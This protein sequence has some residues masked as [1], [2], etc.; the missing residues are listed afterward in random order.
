MFIPTVSNIPNKIITINY[1]YYLN[2]QMHEYEI[3]AAHTRKNIDISMW[4][5]QNH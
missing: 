5:E 1:I 4:I 2:T 3:E